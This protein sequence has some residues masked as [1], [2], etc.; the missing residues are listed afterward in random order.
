[1]NKQIKTPIVILLIILALIVGAYWGASVTL[2]S[3]KNASASSTLYS[4]STGEK[5]NILW[6]IIANNYVDDIE[7]DSISDRIYASLLSALD[8]HSTY[9]TPKDLTAEMESLRGNFEGVGIVLRMINDTI[10]AAQI[11]AGGPAE[12]AGME[13]GDYI[14]SV[15]GEAVSGVKM[16]VEDVVK[17]LR[18][19]R[20]SVADIK[21]K[22]LSENGTRFVKVVR[23]VIETPS[24]SYSGMID[25][26]TG[27]IHLSRFGETTY[28]EFRQALTELKK[29][30]M[31]RLVLDLRDNGGGLMSAATKICDDLL[32]G[33]EMIVYTEGAHQPRQEERSKPGG[34]FGKGDLVVLI[35]EYTASASEI[36]A[37]AMQDND[38][39]IIAGRRSFGKGLV[40]Q[41]FRLPDNSAILLTIA[42]YYTPSG[43][44]IQRPY[45]NG[46][47]EYY[48]DFIQQIINGYA[49]DSLLAQITDST[50]YHTTKG[51]T[52]YGGGGIYPDHII[53][54]KSDTLIVYYNQLVTK[55][56]ISEY[57]FDFVSRKG[58]EIKKQHPDA[59][60]FIAHY[61]VSNDMLEDVFDQAA[62]KGLVRNNNSIK[63][64]REEILSRIKAE[65]GDM[66]YGTPT[67][68]AVML[69]SDPE[70]QEA[71]TLFK[72]R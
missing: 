45:S 1:M 18:G 4:G 21:I 48:E 12:K 61:T 8:P 10:R 66:L 35:N 46:S 59:E 54:Y 31:E 57:V 25:Q 14:L 51:R 29:K 36:V 40:Q 6:N 43:R 68:Q 11:I 39:G 22:R 65:I 67:F 15:N 7:N 64:Y 42:R 19:P 52:V 30:G 17:K 38:R 44:C 9:L 50:P 27:Y 70:L 2:R 72:K 32:P 53:S 49:N 28:S 41:Q 26:R 63:K 62:N 69:W 24:L 3:K 60:D 58:R 55:G 56:I 71:L 13:P 16:K 37:G 23:N 5:T 34:L 47:D 20:K 33:R